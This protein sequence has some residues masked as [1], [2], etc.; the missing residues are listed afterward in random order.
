VDSSKT[1][2]EENSHF[3]SLF[4]FV[5]L[6]SLL[7]QLYE[8]DL[9][10]NINGALLRFFPFILG[11]FVGKKSYEK[12]PLCWLHYLGVLQIFVTYP[13]TESTNAIIMRYM[14]AING[15]M[16]CFLICRIFYC[17]RNL[18]FHPLRGIL[19]FIG[20]YTLELYLTHVMLRVIMTSVGYKPNTI[21][22]EAIMLLFAI[23]LTAMVRVLSSG[24]MKLFHIR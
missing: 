6:I 15:I 22:M 21:Y 19:G 18:K 7:L 12:R 10:G 4:S 24:I 11:T 23:D 5:T 8:P 2:G 13:L 14:L 9:F 20:N 17:T 16:I 3:L 1:A